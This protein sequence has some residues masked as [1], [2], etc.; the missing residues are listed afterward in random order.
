M[1]K[2]EAR[3]LIME[4]LY[5][6]MNQTDKEKF[7][8]ILR[9]SP[10]LQKELKEMQ[11][12]RNLLGQLTSPDTEEQPSLFEDRSARPD[13]R[14]NSISKTLIPGSNSG[15]VFLAAAAVL[16]ISF[17]LASILNLTVS[18]TGNGV[19]ISFGSIPQ[20]EQSGFSDEEVALLIEQVQRENAILATQL[21]EQSQAKQAEQFEDVMRNVVSYFEEQRMKDLQLV[22]NGISR[23]EEETYNRFRQ[24]DE[25]L[26]DLIYAINL[27]QD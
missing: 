10:D 1:N 18:T 25:A 21:I 22:D 5:D 13:N 15:R 4:Y 27:Q 8:Q 9:E 11:D 12:T 2:N 7:E 6:E 20:A 17:L 23:L 16:L 26:V 19:T 24:T 3:S 14:W